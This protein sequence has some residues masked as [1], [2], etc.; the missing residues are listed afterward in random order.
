MAEAHSHASKSKRC[1][2]GGARE[3][4]DPLGPNAQLTTWRAPSPTLLTT[5]PACVIMEKQTV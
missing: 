2:Y 1:I 4:K 5:S 3:L